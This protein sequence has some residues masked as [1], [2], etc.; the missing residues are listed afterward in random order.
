M[1]FV[2]FLCPPCAGQVSS[3]WGR[4][5]VGASTHTYRDGDGELSGAAVA[6]HVGEDQGSSGRPIHPCWQRDFNEQLIS[7]WLR[8]TAHRFDGCPELGETQGVQSSGVCTKQICPH[9]RARSRLDPIGTTNAGGDDLCLGPFGAHFPT[10]QTAALELPIGSET[11]H[12]EVP[13][14][15]TQVRR[16][17]DSGVVPETAPGAPLPCTPASHPATRMS[18]EAV[19]AQ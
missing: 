19:R 17:V 18:I 7:G 12:S 13:P 3:S 8:H 6:V 10:P 15:F 16:V 9:G 5:P 1:G 4:A 14:G 11:P 2:K